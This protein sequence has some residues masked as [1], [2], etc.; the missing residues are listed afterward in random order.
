MGW[1]GRHSANGGEIPPPESRMAFVFLAGHSFTSED[2][3]NTRPCR[4]LWRCEGNSLRSSSEFPD[5]ESFGVAL[6]TVATHGQR[7][8]HG[9]R[10]DANARVSPVV[11]Q[12]DFFSQSS[13]FV[14]FPHISHSPLPR[15]HGC[16]HLSDAGCRSG[17]PGEQ[18]RRPGL[19]LRESPATY[20]KL[21]SE[22]IPRN[23]GTLCAQIATLPL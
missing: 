11:P 22:E 1:S 9:N 19:P 20:W 4:A 18:H 3:M 12:S 8:F 2:H 6:S 21:L 13:L 23:L 15:R 17:R 7:P 16:H 5:R 14:P 10:A